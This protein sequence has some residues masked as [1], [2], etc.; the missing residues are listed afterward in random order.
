MVININILR[1]ID[2]LPK[3]FILPIWWMKMKTYLI[4]MQ[5]CFMQS[6]VEYFSHILKLFVFLFLWSSSW[7][8]LPFF[9]TSDRFLPSL[10]SALSIKDISPLSSYVLQIFFP[11]ICI[12]ILW[13]NSWCHGFLSHYLVKFINLLWLLDFLS[14]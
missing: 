7:C 1:G 9:L 6:D 14:I 2:G 3:L 13:R 8:F 12:L 11:I 10:L 4:F 5:T